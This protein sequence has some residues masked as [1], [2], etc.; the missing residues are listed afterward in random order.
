MTVATCVAEFQSERTPIEGLMVIKPKLFVDQRGY[1]MESFR[2]RD[3][4]EMGIG[5]D[6]VQ[7]N[8]SKSRRGTLRG[9][10]FQKNRPQAKLVRAV[11]GRVFDVAVDLRRDSTT[12]GQWQ[13]VVLDSETKDMFFIPAGFAHG[14]LA[15]TEDAEFGYKCSEYYEGEDEGGLCWND[16]DVGIEWP[17]AG[18]GWPL[19]SEKDRRLPRLRELDWL[20]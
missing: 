10:H 14:F 11:R 8:Q 5:V 12:F 4:E 2:K 1:F 7:E 17:L 18:I 9:L 16:P 3:F 19:L 6:F 13:G 20:F 15:L